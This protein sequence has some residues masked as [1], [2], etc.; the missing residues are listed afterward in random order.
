VAGLELLTSRQFATGVL[1]AHD[2]CFYIMLGSYR[3]TTATTTRAFMLPVI[4]ISIFVG[5][6]DAVDHFDDS[7]HRAMRTTP[8]LK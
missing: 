4:S 6:T 8:L 1:V 7:T 2:S 3:P 5:L